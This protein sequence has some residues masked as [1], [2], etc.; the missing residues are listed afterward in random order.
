MTAIPKKGI[1]SPISSNP[2][3]IGEPSALTLHAVSANNPALQVGAGL[4]AGE[5]IGPYDACYIS[6]GTVGTVN[7]VY[8]S[9]AI[10]GKSRVHGYAARQ[11][12]AQ[13]DPVTLHHGM[14]V[15]YIDTASPAGLA[16][17]GK[18]G[19]PA[20]LSATVPG[21]LDDA[22]TATY[23]I[24][25]VAFILPQKHDPTVKPTG[26]RLLTNNSATA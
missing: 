4:I 20:F 6:D 10:A 26:I 16:Y 11:V 9:Q 1:A 15:E 22:S 13:G 23:G 8:R 21:G 12:F 24:A 5:A 14:D 19:A 7:Y 3:I 18:G 17:T 25:P 2:V